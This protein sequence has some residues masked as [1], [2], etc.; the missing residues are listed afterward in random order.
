MENEQL[1]EKNE[2]MEDIIN[3][4]DIIFDDEEDTDMPTPE[5]EDYNADQ[6]NSDNERLLKPSYK[7]VK[8]FEDCLG[9]LPYASVLKNQ[10][11]EQIKL[12]DL[13]R[14]VEAKTDQMTV[15]EMNTII[16]FLAQCPVEVIRP[17]MEIIEDQ[18]RQPELWTLLN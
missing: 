4:S 11:N 6:S 9:K 3:P 8:L 1:I 7:F 13:I 16:S 10:N 17:L 14:F 15:G 5:T 18:K 2:E 12:L